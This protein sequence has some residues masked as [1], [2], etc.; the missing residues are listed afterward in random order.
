LGSAAL[1]LWGLRMV[2]TGVLRAYGAV[3]RRRLGASMENRFAALFTGLGIT[4]LL[5]SST[6]TALMAAS[7][8]GRGLVGTG[9]ALAVM[10]G[11]DVGT[12][13]VAQALS[14]PIHWLSP[15][16]ILVGVAVFMSGR[17]TRFQ[18]VGRLV[19][20]LGLMLLAL[21]QLT[22]TAVPLRESETVQSLLAGLAGEPILAVAVAA[23]LT[24][25]SASS[26][27]IVL[28][29][30]ALASQGAIDLALAFALV[31]GAN[32]GGGLTPILATS[33]AEPRARRV[34]LGNFLFRLTG[35]VIALPLLDHI[36]PLL[37]QLES[38][39][40]RQISN[41]HTAFNLA[42][43]AVFL[44]LIGPMAKLLG[45][46]WPDRPEPEDAGRA[47]YLDP[48]AMETPSVAIASAARETLRLGDIVAEM[49][50]RTM[51]VFR[52]DDRRLMRE[53]EEMDDTVDRLQ[54]TI[55]L[56]LTKVSRESLDPEESR[57]C[58]DVITFTTNLEHIGDIIDK[59][60]MEL[61][62]KKIKNRLHFSDEGFSEIEKMH[63]RLMENFKL[64]LNVF[65]AGDPRMARRLIEEKVQ[66][67]EMER[68]AS[69]SHLA[70]LRS[71]R[72]ESLETSGLHL[73]VL[74]DL[75]RINSHL[76]SVAY[77]ILETTGALVE[78]RL[79]QEA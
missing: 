11:A 66:F 20:G 8:A 45:R 29:V 17:A 24:V 23:G 9:A 28:L 5:Q 15:L 67:R 37:G 36:A 64:A 61:A 19:V 48:S 50:R 65:I 1:L 69:E 41:L 55:K 34:P 32:L 51:D 60:L 18:D 70:R 56:Y 74:R 38:A 49:L 75:K 54:E 12:S 13:L 53:V 44:P 30:I 43:A 79:K 6:A 31:L 78:S 7:F 73:D 46:I 68:A 47:R 16:L 35:V 33:G 22:A 39:P 21:R 71:G 57:R 40:A 27:A 10:L 25:L 3:L 62:A 77:P 59:N 26:L 76:T 63:E 58:I 2:K 42:L 52:T 72:L 14:F 4:L